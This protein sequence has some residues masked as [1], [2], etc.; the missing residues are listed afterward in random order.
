LSIGLKKTKNTS[1]AS[2]LLSGRHT[3][4]TVPL[5]LYTGQ[6]RLRHQRLAK[7][8]KKTR[9]GSLW[10]LGSGSASNRPGRQ[11]LKDEKKEKN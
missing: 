6:M 3:P 11:L 2:R 5:S 8:Q 4:S 9:K 10:R 1:K 7:E